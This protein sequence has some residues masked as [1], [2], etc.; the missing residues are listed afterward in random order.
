MRWGEKVS[1]GECVGSGRERCS[2]SVKK[3]KGQDGSRDRL[4]MKS[5]KVRIK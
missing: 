4:V 2:A 3:V 1:V 5:R